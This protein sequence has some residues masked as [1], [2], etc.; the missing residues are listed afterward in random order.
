MDENLNWINRSSMSRFNK[1]ENKILI[2]NDQYEIASKYIKSS[3]MVLCGP[4]FERN[5]DN[6]FKIA[7]TP[8]SKVLFVEIIPKIYNHL[9]HC[10]RKFKAAGDQR[11]HK[12]Q[13]VNGNVIAYE[14]FANLKKPYR[15]ENIDLCQ[16][17]N[18]SYEILRYRLRKQSRIQYM[19]KCMIFTV[20]L[21]ANR[22][23][24]ADL[25]T[26][27]HTL[28][29]IIDVIGADIDVEKTINT[30]TKIHTYNNGK[31]NV[32]ALVMETSFNRMGKIFLLKLYK[33]KDNGI[34]MLSGVILYR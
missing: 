11:M 30:L 17:M 2:Q 13:I 9:L 25:L 29:D 5:V 14:E 10:K 23:N 31:C 34:D 1:C 32:S 18:T 27:M 22:K 6:A 20:S 21:R 3:A 8:G 15:F 24:T 12:L 16:S 4:A 33:Y 26:T 7:C 28:N 19:T